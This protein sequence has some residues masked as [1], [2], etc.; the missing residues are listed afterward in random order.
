MSAMVERKLT[1]RMVLFGFLAFFG[2][3]FAVNGVF[4]YF[5]TVSWTGVSSDD[6]YRKGLAYNETIERA[7]VQ[8]ALGWRTAVSL[9]TIDPETDRLTVLLRDQTDKPIDGQVL[10][11]TL[12][13]PV[14]ADE[15]IEVALKQSAAGAYTA[16][17]ALPF[18][19]QWGVYVD[20]ARDDGE[21]YSIEARVWRN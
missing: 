15:D 20:V 12:R 13:R 19:G 14:S 18:R 2:V 11:A 21:P 8:Q 3:V 5:A 4:I 16:D 6:A 17:L 9:E 10:T 1:G 7:A